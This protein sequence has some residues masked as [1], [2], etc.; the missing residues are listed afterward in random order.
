MCLPNSE[1]QEDIEHYNIQ[2][3]HD[4]IRSKRHSFLNRYPETLISALANDKTHPGEE[5]LVL[6]GGLIDLR[7]A[8]NVYRIF[9]QINKY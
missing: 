8:T 7:F 5:S 6:I 2:A 3:S 1:L 9:L 4:R